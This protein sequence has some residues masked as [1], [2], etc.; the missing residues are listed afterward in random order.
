MRLI[1]R[2][3]RNL[4]FWAKVMAVLAAAYLVLGLV[5]WG[6]GSPVVRGWRW[7]CSPAGMECWALALL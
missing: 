4:S 5:L 2:L 6:S 7:V 3:P 1:A